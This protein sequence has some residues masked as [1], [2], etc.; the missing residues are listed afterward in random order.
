MGAVKNALGGFGFNPGSSKDP[1]FGGSAAAAAREAGD[2]QAQATAESI[3]ET[4]RQF[5]ITQETLRPRIEAGDLALE[6]QQALIGLSGEEAQQA[7]FSALSDSPGQQF[8]RQRAQ[9]NLLRNASAIGGLG[10]GNVRSALVEQGAGFA[11][12]DIQ[13]QFGRLGQIAGQG[14]AAGVSSGQFG[15]SSTGNVA[16]LRQIGSEA[17]ASGILGAQQAQSQGASNIVK[18]GATAL[19]FFSDERLKENVKE[20]G[21]DDL[22][23][24]YEFN[25]IWSTAKYLGR[26]AQ[27]LIKSRP[28]AV[29]I[30]ESGYYV[31]TQEFEPR[32]V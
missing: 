18:L 14:Q 32:A 22:G 16:N 26:L 28:D 5:D 3:A 24:F 20:V 1:F 30:H 4:R 19:S 17:R 27:D 9:R 6:Q 2:L 7:S 10:G 23:G 21:R 13:N 8:I 29:D 25:Y 15:A 11:S 31:V 12:Q